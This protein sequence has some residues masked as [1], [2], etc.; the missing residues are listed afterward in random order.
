MPFKIFHAKWIYFSFELQTININPKI[1]RISNIPLRSVG[2]NRELFTEK[3]FEMETGSKLDLL[4]CDYELSLYR[5]KNLHSY[6]Y[7]MIL[8]C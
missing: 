8:V 2:S 5:A 3:K 1:I 7:E 6:G 4:A